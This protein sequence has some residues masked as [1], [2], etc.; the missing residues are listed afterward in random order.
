MSL[1]EFV[2]V[3]MFAAIAAYALL[4]GADFGAGFWDL[5]AGGPEDGRATRVLIERSIGP[6]WEANHVWLIFAL[7][8][9]WT[10]F[11]IA[12]SS[13]MS[14]LFIPLLLVAFGII[15]R[16]SA[17]AFRKEVARMEEQRFFG[18]IFALSSIIT[19]FFLGAIAGGIASGRVPLGN[20]AGDEVTSWW[21]PTSVLGGCLAVVVCAFLAAVY[22][23]RDA[24]RTGD[25]TLTE[26]FRIRA[27][28]AGVVAGV[29]AFIGIFILRDD[30]RNL[31]DELTSRALSLI[32]VSAIAG[33]AT[34]V[35]IWK[36]RY[37][38]ARVSAA[39][40][41]LSVVGGWGVAHWPYL[42]QPGHGFDGLTIDAGASAHETLVTVVV[43]VAGGVV[44]L[45]PS[46]AY[47]FVLASRG[48]L[49]EESAL[50]RPSR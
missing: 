28:L 38:E 27:L 42:L 35:L 22:L 16:G 34:L 40:A 29:T 45:V 41:V 23:C 7:V 33:I 30:A 13:I 26:L 50:S 39:I 47:L 18:A 25:E 1:A 12:F 46:L 8:L 11:S 48:E 32:I 43:V 3:I 36:R 20:A 9:L 21:N 5:T 15:L 24:R 49:V 10:C 44:I 31:Y 2:A 4:A 37:V 19:P 17:F 14:T 6:V